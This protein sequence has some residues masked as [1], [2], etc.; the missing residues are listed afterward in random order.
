M[1]RA[2]G[3][4]LGTRE[5]REARRRRPCAA[6]L[7]CTAW[8]SSPCLAVGPSPHRPPERYPPPKSSW[9]GPWAWH[10]TSCRCRLRR[11][12]SSCQ[13]GANTQPSALGAASSR[14]A[15]TRAKLVGCQGQ[16]PWHDR[17]DAAAIGVPGPTL[18][19][20]RANS[21]ESERAGP[22]SRPATKTR[23]GRSRK[24]SVAPERRARRRPGARKYASSIDVSRGWPAFPS[25]R[26]RGPSP[27][28]GQR[29]AQDPARRC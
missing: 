2:A 12:P 20:A 29:L 1:G 3:R 10:P 24:R 14:I 13:G 25:R 19:P 9:P 23:R 22:S 18:L 11:T 21:G 7:R 28:R 17:G 27:S 5:A 4:R 8:T 15:I 6:I 26:C 16:G